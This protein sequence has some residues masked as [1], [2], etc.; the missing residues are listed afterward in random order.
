MSKRYIFTYFPHATKVPDTFPNSAAIYD[1]E[2]KLIRLLHNAP[3]GDHE[4]WLFHLKKDIGERNEVS[5]K[6]PKKVAEL[7]Q[8]TGPISRENRGHL[9]NPK[10][11][12][13]SGSCIHIQTK[14]D[15][16]RRPIQKD[17]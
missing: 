17:G 6:Y 16:L 4:H 13:Q 2:W 11:Q 12:L 15:L 5:K 3:N 8:G 9:S 14:K 1:D 10:P 7:W